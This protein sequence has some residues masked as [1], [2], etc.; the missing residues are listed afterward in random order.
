VFRFT[1]SLALLLSFCLEVSSFG[2]CVVQLCKTGDLFS[3]FLFGVAF[4]V[5]SQSQSLAVL[6]SF[7]LSASFS[8]TSLVDF[9]LF[10]KVFLCCLK[11]L[12]S[13]FN[14]SIFII[15]SS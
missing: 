14:H 13:F 11:V 7:F 1:L 6:Y 5:F 15:N 10:L 2:F 9:H 8:L 12:I 3:S 4:I